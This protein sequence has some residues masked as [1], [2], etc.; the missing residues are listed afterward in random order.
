MNI[1]KKY[2]KCNIC[3]NYLKVEKDGGSI[4]T[5]CG[6]K[7]E[8]CTKECDDKSDKCDDEKEEKHEEKKEEQNHKSSIFGCSP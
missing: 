8:V 1:I 7:M 6:Q 5:C 3:G 2:Y 4:P